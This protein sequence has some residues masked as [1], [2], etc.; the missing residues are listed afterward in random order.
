[1]LVVNFVFAVLAV[2]STSF[3]VV[4][5][6]ELVHTGDEAILEVAVH[7][8][9][10]PVLFTM[11]SSPGA[12]S[13]TASDGDR[14]DLPG[15]AHYRGVPTWVTIQV[16]SDGP[17]GF[18]GFSHTHGAAIRPMWIAPRP[19]APEPPLAAVPTGMV[20][21]GPAASSDTG[22]PVS[23]REFVPGDSRQRVSWPVT[24]R[25]GRLMAKTFEQESANR[26]VMVI[27]LDPSLSTTAADEVCARAFWIGA[28]ILEQGWTLEVSF[29]DAH[30]A[31]VRREVD[32]AGLHRV[33]AEAQLGLVPY[34]T[35]RPALLVA[36]D[37]IAW[38]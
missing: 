8:P 2:R 29:V 25:A 28:S 26:V 17:L 16:R 23:V 19:E 18:I 37:R 12:R 21:T 10:A 3:D 6:P 38:L 27:R 9:K 35:A 34:P 20:A 36:H 32:R 22:T 11:T 7:G 4:A 13:V 24:A 1:V 33:V 14:I 5:Q 30:R 31:P 15:L